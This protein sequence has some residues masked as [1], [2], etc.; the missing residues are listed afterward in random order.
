MFGVG[1]TVSNIRPT[2]RDYKGDD[3]IRVWDKHSFRKEFKRIEIRSSTARFNKHH[4]IGV[5][6]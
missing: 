1:G 2:L 6:N 3:C 4:G 5:L